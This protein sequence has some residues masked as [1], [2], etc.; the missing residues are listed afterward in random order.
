MRT[1][2]SV[3]RRSALSGDLHT[4]EVL[5]EHGELTAWVEQGFRDGPLLIQQC[6][7]SASDEDREFILTGITPEEWDLTFREDEVD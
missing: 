6:I 2:V 3:T 4:R 7:P 5:I 1:L